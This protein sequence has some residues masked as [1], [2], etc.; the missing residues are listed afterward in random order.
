[1]RSKVEQKFNMS[2]VRAQMHA[3]SCTHTH[4][5]GE[6]RNKLELDHYIRGKTDYGGRNV[7]AGETLRR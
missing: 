1:M 3:P 6:R 2:H 5:Q 7:M 4:T